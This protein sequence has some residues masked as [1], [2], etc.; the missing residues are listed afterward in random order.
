[1]T[2][3]EIFGSTIESI[4][5]RENTKCPR[6]VVHCIEAI[7]N[8]GLYHDGI[9]RVSGNQAEIQSIRCKID[10]QQS[11]SL[12]DVQDV[13][14]LTG[15]LKLFFRELQEPLIPFEVFDEMTRALELEPKEKLA[16]IQSCINKLPECRLHTFAKLIIHLRRVIALEDKNRMQ[17]Q[18][19]AIVF[20][21]NLMW[22][23]EDLNIT[24]AMTAANYILDLILSKNLQFPQ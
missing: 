19:I 2:D 15:A 5:E 4:C 7:E 18:G 8:K 14:V 9:Y 12:D 24:N 20:G 21:P 22:Q 10:Q 17:A 16:K 13:N 11:N 1:M 3:R 23:K 6:F